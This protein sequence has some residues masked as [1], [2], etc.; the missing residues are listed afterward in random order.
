MRGRC[1]WRWILSLAKVVTIGTIAIFG[2]IGVSAILKKGSGENKKVVLQETKTNAES[3][4]MSKPIYVRP[5]TPALPP[6]PIPPPPPVKPPPPPPPPPSMPPSAPAENAPASLDDFPNID[7][8]QALFTTGPMKLPIVE[9]ITYASSVPWIKGRPAWVADYASYYGTSRHFIARSLNGKADYFSQKVSNGSRFNVFKKDKNINF[10]LLI[11]VS[12]RKMGFYYVDLDTQ[13]RVLLKTYKVSLGRIDGASPSGCLTPL[14]KYSLGSKTAVYKP[15]VMGYFQDQ[16]IEM[17]QVFG[18]RWV[19]F[20][21]E[22][23]G[24]T[25]SAKGYGIH[26]VPCMIDQAGQIVENRDCIGKY[27]GDGCIRLAWEDM[28]ELFAIVITKPTFVLI[29]KDFHEA[30]LPGKEIASPTR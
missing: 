14:G 8:I 26:G 9:T 15:G 23:E 13:E 22:L 29:V 12:L 3:Q 18:T 17:I 7:R 28:E 24:A 2:V 20:D 16:T 30:M 6:H 10:Y 5:E 4:A 19:P 27:D 11:D 1:T 21:Q 25:A